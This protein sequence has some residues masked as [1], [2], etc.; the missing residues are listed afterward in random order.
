MS[1]LLI[2]ICVFIV[3][4]QAGSSK[5]STMATMAKYNAVRDGMT[6]SEVEHIFG[7]KGQ[8]I[9]AGGPVKTVRWMNSEESGAVINFTDGRVSMKTQSMLP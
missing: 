6:Q 8:E 4:C 1:K 7:F 3:G 2:A 9:L 5:G